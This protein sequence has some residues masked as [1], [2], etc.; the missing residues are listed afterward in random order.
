MRNRLREI[1]I[2]ARTD[3]NWNLEQNKQNRNVMKFKFTI[4]ITNGIS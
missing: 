4:D 2:A 3:V 1:I